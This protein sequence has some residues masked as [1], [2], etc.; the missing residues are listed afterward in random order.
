MRNIQRLKQLAQRTLLYFADV[1]V[2]KLRAVVRL[3]T[4]NPERKRFL[5]SLEEVYRVGGGVFFISVDK[6][7]TSTFINGCP[8]I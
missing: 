3:D 6:T 1:F 7:N 4:L 8:L 5:Q 2:G